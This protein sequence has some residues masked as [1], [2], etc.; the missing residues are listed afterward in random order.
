MANISVP[1]HHISPS[2]CRQ[3]RDGEVKVGPRFQR[4][5]HGDSLASDVCV[6]LPLVRTYTESQRKVGRSY[7]MH[8]CKH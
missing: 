8:P 7:L 3:D 1:D 5:C 6:D 2:G 4:R